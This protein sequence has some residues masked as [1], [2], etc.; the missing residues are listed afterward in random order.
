MKLSSL[1]LR[2]KKRGLIGNI[3]PLIN[4][5]LEGGIYIHQDIVTGILHE[6]RE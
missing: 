4:K 2:A 3:R 1:L 6:A 5:I